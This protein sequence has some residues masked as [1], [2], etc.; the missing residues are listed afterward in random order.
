MS[1]GG[2]RAGAGRPKG[3][4]N[5]TTSELARRAAEDGLSPAQCML[6][7]MRTAYACGD[8]ATALDA[9]SKVAAYV[10]PRLSAVAV[11]LRDMNVDE[12]RALAG[13]EE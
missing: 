6:S 9:A 12:L 8:T 10:H 13:G 2:S 11:D 3:S 1:R 5:R 7:I 4:P